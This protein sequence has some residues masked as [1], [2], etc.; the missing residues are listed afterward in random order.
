MNYEFDRHKQWITVDGTSF[1]PK[2]FENDTPIPYFDTRKLHDL[3]I[4]LHEWFNKEEFVWVKTSGSTGKPKH[5]K[6]D[7][8]RMM[9]SAKMTCTFLGLKTGD[10]ALLCMKLDYIAGKMVVVR[11]LLAK[12]NLIVIS[13]SGNPLQEIETKI[14]FAALIPLQVYN[15]LSNPN[16]KQKLS[17][18]RNLIIGGGAIDREIGE[19]LRSFPNN[20]FSTYGMTETLSHIALRKLNGP[21]ASEFY[22]PLEGI[23]LSV[24][25]QGSLVIDAPLIAGERLETNDLV[26][27]LP[28]QQFR[29]TGRIDNVINSGGIKIQVEELEQLLRPILGNSFAITSLPD[30]KFGEIVVLVATEPIDELILAEHLPPYHLPKKILLIEKLP[31]T[32]TGKI[33]RKTL[34]EIVAKNKPSK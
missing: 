8:K 14:D 1:S 2:D 28:S 26:E 6:A 10:S 13:P 24:S 15:C 30:S 23:S 31:L 9:E 19:A 33:E 20:I 18:I 7:K 21:S 27:L 17:N 25:E 4:F 22:T 16:E 34:K 29:I 32:E 3:Y 11:S 5:L 12:L